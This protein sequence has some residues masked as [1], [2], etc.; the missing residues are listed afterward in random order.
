MQLD[1]AELSRALAQSM[2]GTKQIDR[3]L[4][5]MSIDDICSG[6]DEDDDEDDEDDGD[7]INAM[8]EDADLVSE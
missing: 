2:T 3:E 7:D 6:D 5:P 4:N 1:A 8:D